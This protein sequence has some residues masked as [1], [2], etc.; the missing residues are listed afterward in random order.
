MSCHQAK[1]GA[2]FLICPR[3]WRCVFRK[4]NNLP[5]YFRNILKTLY[6]IFRNSFKDNAFIVS[7]LFE[8]V[9]WRQLLVVKIQPAFKRLY[10]G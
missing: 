5:G 6:I 7:S 8:F 9:F 2:T 4:I 10:M 3:L 1:F